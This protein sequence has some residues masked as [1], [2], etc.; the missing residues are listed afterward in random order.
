MTNLEIDE[1]RPHPGMEDNIVYINHA[2]NP[3]FSKLHKSWSNVELFFRIDDTGFLPLMMEKLGYQVSYDGELTNEYTSILPQ[4]GTTL[5]S[6]QKKTAFVP[7]S[8]GCN[9]FCSYCIVPYARGMEKNMPSDQILSEVKHHLDNGIQEITLLG[10]IVNKYPKF[11]QLCEDILSLDSGD[12]RWLRYTSPYPTFYSDK[13]LSLHENDPR[14]CP[15]I[16]MPLQSGS[17][18]VLKKMFRGYDREQCLTFIDKIR[19]LQRPISLT[20]DII[21]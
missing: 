2:F 21:V 1:F 3:L 8:T 6:S 16:H 12:L 14:M 20:T 17:T 11:D 5:L 15:H 10:Q 7:I 9:Q 18:A 19:S 4:S 13:L